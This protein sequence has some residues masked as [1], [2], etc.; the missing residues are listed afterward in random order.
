[1][2]AVIMLKGSTLVNLKRRNRTGLKL[3][4]M[5]IAVTRFRRTLD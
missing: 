1:M 4:A 3:L 5:L 2:V